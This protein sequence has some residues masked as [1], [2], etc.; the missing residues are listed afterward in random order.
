MLTDVIALRV[1]HE[2]G[3]LSRA[4]HQIVDGDVN[5][6]YMYAFANGEDASAVLKCDDPARVVDIL[7][8]SGFDVWRKEEV[9]PY[10]QSRCLSQTR[11]GSGRSRRCEGPPGVISSLLKPAIMVIRGSCS[12]LSN[13]SLQNVKKETEGT[14][15]SSN[16]IH[17]ST[18][19]KAHFCEMYSEGS[20][21]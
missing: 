15:S 16:T 2:T 7:R 9:C 1:P 8:G 5:I 19:E 10:F 17:L 21:P 14:S 3:S 6:E 4:M 18:I 20:Q 12:Y 11:A 13:I